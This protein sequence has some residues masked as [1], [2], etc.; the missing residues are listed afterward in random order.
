MKRP[1]HPDKHLDQLLRDAESQGWRVKKGTKYYKLLCPCS[2]KHAKWS[3][4]LTP[5][6]P[7]Y[8]RNLRQWLADNTCWQ[9]K[10]G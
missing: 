6:N 2:G 9:E 5:S 1:R 3:V 8:E 4:H 10:E 7:N